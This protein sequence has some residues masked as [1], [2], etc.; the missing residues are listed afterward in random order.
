MKNVSNI[1]SNKNRERKRLDGEVLETRYR[2]VFETAK[3]GILILDADTGLIIDVNPFLIKLLGYSKEHFIEKALWE[4]G[5]FKD[6][7]ENKDKF[8]ELLTKKYVRYDDLPLE[9]ADGRQIH[10]EFVSNVYLMNKDKAIQCNIRDI[11]ERKK[12]D[13]ERINTN[14]ILDVN[15]QINHAIIN[16]HQKKNL[17]KT[18][19]K[20]AARYGKY[21]MA[22]IGMIDEEEKRVKPF[23]W[24]GLEEGFLNEVNKYFLDEDTKNRCPARLAINKGAVVIRNNIA[25]ETIE[26]TWRAEALKRGYYSS[27]TFPIRV[28]GK[29]V[30]AFTLF[31]EKPDYFKEEEIQRLTDVTA[32]ISFAL[33]AI[34]NEIARR[35][36]GKELKNYS[37]HLE[38]TIKLRT[39]ELVTANKKLLIQNQEKEKRAAELIIANK[40]LVFQNREKEKRAAELAIANKELVYQNREK[41]KRAAELAIANKELVFQNKEKEKRAAELAIANKELVFQN[42]EKEKRAAELVIANKELVFQ[43]KE[44]EKRAAEIIIANKELVFQN[45]EKEKRAAEL[46]VANKEL[47]FQNNEKEKRAAELIIA[48][49]E[50]VFQY[51]EKEKR[52]AELIIALERAELSD[53]LKSVFLATMSHELRTPLN[54]IIGFSGILLQE[55]PGP[56]NEEQKKQLGMV[57]TS[58]RHLLSLI[59]MILD[60]SRIEAG[61]MTA[62]NGPFNIMEVIEDILKILSP[63][64]ESKEIALNITKKP[65]NG[66]IISDRQRVHQVLLNLVNNAIKFTEKGSVSISCYIESKSIK[67]EITD[68]G[69]G[70]EEENMTGIFDPFIQIDN[71][72]TRKY[73]G[74]GL[75]LSISQKLMEILH[76]KIEVKSEVGVGSSFIIT[77][78]AGD[79]VM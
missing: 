51:N 55:N 62:T 31:T 9:K 37:I 58:G 77:L 52:A 78:P 75:G 56:L 76:G 63:Y 70:I 72:L 57:Q 48:N 18:I 43:N 79:V 45:K 41:E 65:K 66:E 49:K 17:L 12:A 74:S 2:R 71:N 33:E 22:W 30:G 44:K 67:V 29:V 11:S 26:I 16:T 73:E 59:N 69:I 47:I 50:L 10:V 61:E 4:I 19:C 68:T 39:K 8:E 6:K 1:L 32:N 35:Q 20:V 46:V 25:D 60:I 7:A 34:E 40:E 27:A 42:K 38:R 21:K 54:S 36:I 15:S 24:D 3:D 28:F 53:R 5:F 13:N 14:R 23:A 64:A